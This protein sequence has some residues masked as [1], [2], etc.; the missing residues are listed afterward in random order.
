MMANGNTGGEWNINY[1]EEQ[2]QVWRDRAVKVVAMVERRERDEAVVDKM[3]GAESD[4]D[5]TENS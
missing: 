3:F 5:A 4:D 2:R 1:T